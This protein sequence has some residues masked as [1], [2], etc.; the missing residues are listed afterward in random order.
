MTFFYKV[1]QGV[2]GGIT[3]LIGNSSLLVRL[4][5]VVTPATFTIYTL[6]ANML[7]DGPLRLSINY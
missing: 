7:P 1:L 6:L 4:I 2:C 5:F 3:G